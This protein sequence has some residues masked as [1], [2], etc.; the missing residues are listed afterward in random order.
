MKPTV[1][2]FSFTG[3]SG[4]QLEIIHQEDIFL[5]LM[6]KVKILHFPMVQEKNEFAPIDIAIVEGSIS[7]EEHA[8]KIKTIRE[9][10]RYLIAIGSCA[11]HGGV[12]AIRNPAAEKKVEQQVYSG[13]NRFK[14]IKAEGIDKYVQ[15]DYYVRGCP[16]VKEDFD[17]AFKQLLLHAKPFVYNQPVCSE[18]RYKENRCLLRD[19]ELCLGPIT[20]GGCGA[21][22][23]SNNLACD[24][25]RGK[26]EDANTIA[27]RECLEQNGISK[28][29]AKRSLTLYNT[30]IDMTTKDENDKHD[31]IK[32]KQ[33]PQPKQQ[34]VQAVPVAT[35]Q[36]TAQ[37]HPAEPVSKR[38]VQSRQRTAPKRARRSLKK[39]RSK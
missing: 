16:P 29:D 14:S 27:L 7:T 22:C 33:Q 30:D 24:G 8:R 38:R 1:G 15:V 21:M 25:C 9:K 18:C 20:F 26:L 3:C 13:K 28:Q 2:I 39:R 37:K 5:E 6:D 11:T 17:R 32:L 34:T 31:A 36:Q 4:C 10:A 12:N 35:K 19:G 23:P